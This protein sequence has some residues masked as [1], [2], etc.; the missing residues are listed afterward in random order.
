MNKT[1]NSTSWQLVNVTVNSVINNN[2]FVNNIKKCNCKW[3]HDIK[4]C[5]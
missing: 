3:D 4:K 1:I 2:L 5:Y